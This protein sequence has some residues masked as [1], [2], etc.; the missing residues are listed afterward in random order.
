MD[1]A[2]LLA[3]LR[4][5]IEAPEDINVLGR[6]G[7]SGD[8]GV[9]KTVF[10]LEVAQI[11]TPPDKEILFIDWRDGWKV[12]TNPRHK[13]LAKRMQRMRYVNYAQLEVLVQAISATNPPEP[14]D[15]IGTIVLD[16]WSSM[17]DADIDSVTQSQATLEGRNPDVT[18]WPEYNMSKNRFTRL[19]DK[20]CKLDVQIVTVTHVR[21]NK[22]LKGIEAMTP[23]FTKEILPRYVRPLDLSA[24]M[25]AEIITKDNSTEPIYTR[26]L[27]VH[28]TTAVYG[29]KTRIQDLPVNVGPETLLTAIGEFS[30]GLRGADEVADETPRYDDRV[31]DPTSHE[32]EAL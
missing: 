4:S 8:S 30:R 3:D 11:V 16:E 19:W 1:P 28:P 18:T 23:S 14:F 31:N 26:M 13:H 15:K 9:G 32:I 20:I 12:L 24:W 7:I 27:Q 22:T 6:Y 5:T 17:V 10:G 29:F 2:Q 21:R 25:T